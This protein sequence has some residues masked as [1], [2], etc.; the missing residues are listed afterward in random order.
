MTILSIEACK[1]VTLPNLKSVFGDGHITIAN[2]VQHII[3]LL[4]DKTFKQFYVILPPSILSKDVNVYSEHYRQGS[5]SQSVR[6]LP[7]PLTSPLN[8]R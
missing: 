8:F 6:Y 3:A 1:E 7:Y 4:E 2:I 5:S